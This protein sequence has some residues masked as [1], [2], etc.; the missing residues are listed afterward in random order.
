VAVAIQNDAYQAAP[1]NTRILMTELAIVILIVLLFF[2]IVLGI[3]NFFFPIGTSI[4]DLT[5][6]LS[7]SVS[8][9]RSRELAISR[10]EGELKPGASLPISAKVS[11]IDNKVSVKLA[12]DIAWATARLGMPL[13]HR[14]AIQTY[15]RARA[16]VEFDAE[17]YLEVGQNSLVVFQKME[18]DL[19]LPK[20][21]TFRVM[22]EGELR[23]R[24][25][26]SAAGSTSLEVALPGTNL[27]VTP[28]QTQGE[29]V[30]FRLTVNPDKSSTLS[31]HRG[32]AQLLVGGESVL[33]EGNHGLT[34][35]PDGQ[36]QSIVPLPSPPQPK[37][38]VE[39]S[40]AYYRD[41]PPR[42]NF[43]WQ[44]TE[45]AQGYRLTIA[46]DPTFRQLVVDEQLS[47]TTFRHG[48]LKGGAY[49]W[50]VQSIKGTVE[51]APSEPRALRIVQDH[52]PPLL[53][54]QKPPKVVRRPTITLRGKTEAGAKIYIEGRPVKV[55]SDGG[56]RHRV[57]VKPG[58]SLIVVEAVDAA[59][60]V[61][62]STNLVNRKYGE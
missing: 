55:D 43:S 32:N 53:S 40:A 48:N 62:Y 15:E 28:S 52:T 47:G 45:T 59:G 50:R 19:F 36:P 27:Q 22:V 26:P 11:Y 5:S 14:D 33:V 9:T 46:R 20:A 41:L 25:S 10:G 30:E 1:R 35:G 13:Y 17:N 60:N 58:A 38:P 49:Y 42:L 16:L 31:V 3:T 2:S 54:V 18:P 21:R 4:K 29:D 12:N 56:F 61:A 7:E 24:L 57:H 51:G 39:G 8:S 23:G 44:P 34:I 37:L 6:S